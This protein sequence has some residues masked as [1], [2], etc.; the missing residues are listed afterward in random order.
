V[1]LFEM[2][3]LKKKNIIGLAL[4]LLVVVLAV[5]SSLFRRQFLSSQLEIYKS[6]LS[7]HY[8]ALYRYNSILPVSPGGAGDLPGFIRLYDANGVLL[9]QADVEMVQLVSDII[10]TDDRVTIK[11]IA[12]WPLSRK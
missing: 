2:T 6:P 11:F 3:L 12:D 8:L 4:V 5:N 7:G 1:N 10:W 9:N